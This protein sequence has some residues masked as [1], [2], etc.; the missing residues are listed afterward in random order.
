MTL[1]FEIFPA[2][3]DAT[4]DFYTRVLGFRV[5][6]DERHAADAYLSLQRDDVHIGAV[7][8]PE[9]RS[10]AERRP[11][12]GVEIVLEVDDIDAEHCRVLAAGWPV[13]DDL[14]DRPWGLGDF[15]LLDPD[16]YYLRITN[17]R[18]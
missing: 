5:V 9:V 6:R 16:G 12:V 3:L 4:A 15:R 2:A 13:A 18:T 1:R 14:E 8:R 10:S 17:R 7:E 11:P